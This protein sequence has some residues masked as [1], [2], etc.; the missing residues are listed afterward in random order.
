M[1]V[2][3]WCFLSGCWLYSSNV[4]SAQASGLS[5]PDP[6]HIWTRSGPIGSYC[7][8]WREEHTIK[9]L[10]W[11]CH[12]C[13]LFNIMC[14]QC[15]LLPKNICKIFFW[16]I[17]KGMHDHTSSICLAWAPLLP[18]SI[19]SHAVPHSALCPLGAL[20]CMASLQ[21]SRKQILKNLSLGL[22]WTVPQRYPD[23]NKT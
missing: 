3:T 15:V 9:N 19:T 23:R 4:L 12:F 16:Q 21:S 10:Y 5:A 11:K 2:R 18:C 1:P 7:D 6:L 8:T 14:Y 17:N 22:L 20:Q 13:K